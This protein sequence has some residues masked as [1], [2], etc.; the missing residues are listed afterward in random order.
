MYP[1]YLVTKFV[2]WSK[3][4]KRARVKSGHFIILKCSLRFPYR[5][6]PRV[7]RNANEPLKLGFQQKHFSWNILFIYHLIRILDIY[8]VFNKYCVISKILK[9]ILG[10]AT[11]SVYAGL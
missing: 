5:V 8:R 3:Y 10:I 7:A 11:V 6:A 4:Y 1:A 9:Y 2:D